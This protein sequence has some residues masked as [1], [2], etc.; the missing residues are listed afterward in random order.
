MCEAASDSSHFVGVKQKT[1]VGD[2]YGTKSNFSAG[3]EMNCGFVSLSVF[4]FN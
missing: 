3:G 4:D 1:D 2:W